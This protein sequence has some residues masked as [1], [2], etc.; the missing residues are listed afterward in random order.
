M[1]PS[2]IINHIDPSTAL[3]KF[4]TAPTN[5]LQVCVVPTATLFT[6]N[7]GRFPIRAMSEN[8]YIML[9]YH[10]ATNAIFVQPFQTKA[11]HHRIP[12][13]NIIMERLKAQNITV[14]TQ[15]LDN[16]A[17]A[18]YIHCITHKWK[19][20]HQKVPPDMHCRNKSDRAIRTS[21]PTFSPS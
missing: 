5:E 15:V 16:E 8:Q 18:T 7:M 14:D 12:A 6:D 13:Y 10:N 1:Y 19:C 9:A 20:K 3:F 11:D 4:I 17:S 2:W 21:K